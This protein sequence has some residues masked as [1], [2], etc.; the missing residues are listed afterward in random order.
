M[1][2]TADE[3]KAGRYG[4][5]LNGTETITGRNRANPGGDVNKGQAWRVPILSV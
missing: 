5:Q 3:V 2:A 1:L 4:A